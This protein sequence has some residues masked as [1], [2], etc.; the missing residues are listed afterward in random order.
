MQCHRTSWK[1]I[2][3]TLGDKRLDEITPLD[4]EKY[5]RKRQKAGVTDISINRE[6]GFLRHVF[7]TAINWDQATENPVKKV[8]FAKEDNGRIRFL[9][10]DEEARLLVH[11]NETLRPVVIAALH[12]GLRRSELLSLGK[13]SILIAKWSRYKQRM[14]KMASVVVYR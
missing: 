13:R 6:L 11:C 8:R 14:P 5:R 2:S 1:A 9:S 10:L 3:S 4:L 12:T 7:S